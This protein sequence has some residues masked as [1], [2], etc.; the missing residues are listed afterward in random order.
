MKS[1]VGALQVVVPRLIVCVAGTL[2]PAAFV[3]ISVTV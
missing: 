3:T 2:L 1:A